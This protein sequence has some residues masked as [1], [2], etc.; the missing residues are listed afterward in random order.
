MAK[1]SLKNNLRD[2]PRNKTNN[3]SRDNVVIN[4]FSEYNALTRK[5][6]CETCKLSTAA[7]FIRNAVAQR[8]EKPDLRSM[9]QLHKF[10]KDHKLIKY[11]LEYGAMRKHV[12]NC[13]RYDW[14]T[15]QYLNKTNG[16][17]R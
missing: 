11:P 2:K 8:Y 4:L 13:L 7:E 17:S 5:S 3:Q 12:M 14:Q 9:M 15:N 6:K 16:D 10:M 1:K